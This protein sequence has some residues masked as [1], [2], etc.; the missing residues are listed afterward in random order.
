MQFYRKDIDLAQ[1]VTNFKN[2]Q[3]RSDICA[4]FFQAAPGSNRKKGS[5]KIYSP[6]LKFIS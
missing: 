2:A 3:I 5:I 6:L 4:A 1:F